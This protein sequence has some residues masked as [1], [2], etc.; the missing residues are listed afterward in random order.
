VEENEAANPVAIDSLG[1]QAE[2]LSPNDIADLIQEFRLV[3]GG[4]GGYILGHAPQFGD[5]SPGMQ[6]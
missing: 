3:V 6:P 2:M 1:S 4:R 5:F